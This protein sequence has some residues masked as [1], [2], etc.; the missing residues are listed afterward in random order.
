LIFAFELLVLLSFII[1][2]KFLYQ[3]TGGSLRFA[4]ED[5]RILV[6]NN[7]TML[8]RFAE[9]GL[10]AAA[11]CFLIIQNVKAAHYKRTKIIS[12]I[13]FWLP[14]IA[15][16]YMGAR[17]NFFFYLLIFLTNN[18]LNKKKTSKKIKNKHQILIYGLI[19]FMILTVY[20]LFNTRGIL[21]ANELF[22]I[23]PGDMELRNWANALFHFTHGAINPI[24]KILH[25]FSHGIPTFTYFFENYKPT[26]YS[27]GL[28]QFQFIEYILMAFGVRVIEVNEILKTV[29]GHGLY[30]TFVLGFVIDWG[31]MFAPV[32]IFINGIFFG[33]ISSSRNKR[34]FSKCFYPIVL[35]MCLVSP[36]YY[37]WSVGGVTFD[38]F[39]LLIIIPL[40]K[41][42]GAR[43][44]YSNE[45]SSVK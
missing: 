35:S 19:T 7:R 24:F 27:Y 10:H 14:P 20:S 33:R 18:K 6:G 38:F 21:E 28:Y 37:F 2:V 4:S 1:Y 22:L 30:K 42:L 16:L 13:F 3:V 29:A 31:F 34:M 41:L 17:W 9:V 40:I 23:S 45:S 44:D 15:Y 25:Y 11:P 12:S 36:V 43:I 26:A 32:A 5:I 8:S 39:F